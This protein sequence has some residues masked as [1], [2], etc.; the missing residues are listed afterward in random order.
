MNQRNEPSLVNFG[1]QIIEV[2]PR[3]SQYAIS[4]RLVP[5]DSDKVE[6][7]RITASNLNLVPLAVNN[8]NVLEMI[9]TLKQKLATVRITRPERDQGTIKFL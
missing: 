6:P 1:N 2:R 5:S 7:I 4:K 8:E 9:P 3:F